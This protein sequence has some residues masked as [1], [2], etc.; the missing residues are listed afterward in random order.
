MD[1]VNGRYTHIKVEDG[2][3]EE[4][5]LSL[6][7]RALN[8]SKTE[9]PLQ[10]RQI[11]CECKGSPM[12]ISLLASLMQEHQLSDEGRWKYYLDSLA[13]RKYSKVGRC[14]G[15]EHGSIVDAIS[16]S[17]EGLTEANQTLYS[18]FALF[19]DDVGIPCSVSV[20]CES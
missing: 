14:R 5:S 3:T 20:D 11:H 17:F 9:L 6:F 10:A 18:D 2:F 16:L 13:K 12:V 1:V 8:I 19:Q 4:E 15:Y 7:S